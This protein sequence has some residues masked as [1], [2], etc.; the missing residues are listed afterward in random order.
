MILANQSS[1]G[2]DN[3]KSI[4]GFNYVTSATEVLFLQSII[5]A[6]RHGGRCS[7]VMLEN[8]LFLTKEDAFTNTK[9]KL[10]EA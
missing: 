2:Q 5:R 4:T 3:T 1:G 9:E 8:I 6:L 10:L 7:I